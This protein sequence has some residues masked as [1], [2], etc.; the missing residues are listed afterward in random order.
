MPN[1]D[2]WEEEQKGGMMCIPKY[3][4][5]DSLLGHVTIVLSHIIDG[6]DDTDK[7]LGRVYFYIHYTDTL[8]FFKYIGFENK[9]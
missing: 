5:D 3:K 4:V 6:Q 8:P 1:V 2:P 7:V 9:Q